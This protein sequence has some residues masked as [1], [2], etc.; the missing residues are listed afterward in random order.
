MLQILV[1]S[2]LT[3]GELPAGAPDLWEELYVPDSILE[4]P[5]DI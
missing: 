1:S 5:V 3:L 4:P 2:S